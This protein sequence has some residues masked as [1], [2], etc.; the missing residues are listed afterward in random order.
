MH[1]SNTLFLKSC[2]PNCEDFVHNQNIWIK[3]G[4]YGE[5]KPYR[6]SRGVTL[7]RCVNEVCDSSKIDNFIKLFVHLLAGHA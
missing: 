7:D 6:H 1:F 3:M 4:C 2:I 5:A